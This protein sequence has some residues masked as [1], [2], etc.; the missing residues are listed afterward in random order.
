[1]LAAAGFSDEAILNEMYLS[2]EPA[3]VFS[4]AAERGLL[5]QLPLHSQTSQ[6][7]QLRALLGTD[8]ADVAERLSRVLHR[9]IL[10][11]AFAGEWSA[12]PEDA[13]PR[14][15]EQARQHPL[16]AAEDAVLGRRTR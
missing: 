7:G 10:S 15:T 1:V 13:V 11:G 3:E 12:A 5:G 4:Q 2:G 16:S 9:D 8:T 6:Y 14:L